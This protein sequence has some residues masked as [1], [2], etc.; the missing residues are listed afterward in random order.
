MNEDIWKEYRDQ[1][2]SSFEVSNRDLAMYLIGERDLEA[3]L[4]AIKG[5]LSRNQQ[6]DEALEAK[7]KQLD[8][9]IRAN[10]HRSAM[11]R[12]RIEDDWLDSLHYGIFQDAAHSMAAVGML[13]PFIES[14]FVSIFSGLRDHERNDKIASNDDPKT[15]TASNESWDPQRV[16]DDQ[17]RRPGV[18]N[19]ILRVARATGMAIYLPSGYDKV[20][21][22][23]FAYRNKMFH[24]GFEW[25]KEERMKFDKRVKSGEWP[26][27]WFGKATRDHEPWIFYMSDG[28]ITHCLE[29]I[30]EVL[31]GVGAYFR[32]RQG[33]T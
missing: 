16:Y 24:L 22:A 8:E 33:L 9:E 1:E 12:M 23:L 4:L 31:E 15:P 11:Y 5:L 19:G 2:C 25:P 17:W 30:D 21:K 26:A 27:E 3:Q 28:F 7:I 18:V 14:F 6:D 29:T 20:L 10:A 32:D 13:A